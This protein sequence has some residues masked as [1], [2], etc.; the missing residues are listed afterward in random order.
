MKPGV[1]RVY[2]F[3]DFT[4]DLEGHRLA[5][6]T[7]EIPLQP[8]TFD[9]L[10]CLLE[11]PGRL[12]TKRELHDRVWGDVAVTDDALTRCIVA[13]RK[14]LGDGASRP[15]YIQTVP[16]LG[17]RFI[18]SVEAVDALSIEPSV[19]SGGGRTARSLV[20]L[21]FLNLSQDPEQEYF[22]DGFTDLLIADLGRIAALNVI[23]RTSAMS[24]RASAKPLPEIGR[25]LGVDAAVEGS[26]LRAGSR[27]RI[28]VQLIDARRDRHLW[29]DSYER[30]LHDILRL[31]REVAQD[32]ASAIR[33]TLTPDESKRLG[34]AR[35]VDPEV[36]ELYLRG[37]Y[38]WHKRTA[39]GVA[40]SVRLFHAAIE[41]DA[42]Y[43]P[44]YAGL[45]QASGVAGFFGYVPPSQAF[46]EMKAYAARALALDPG[47]AEAHACTGAVRLFYE[48]D[49]NAAE[50]CF[51]RALAEN[52]SYPVAHEWYGWCLF[53]LGRTDAGLAEV[54][55]ARELDPLS[56]HARAAE[57]MSLYFARR[58][59][60]AIEQLNA[61]MELDARFPD[62]H[63]GLG[64][65][66]LQLGMHD[67]AL[68]Q[69]EEA[70]TLSGRSA[71]DVASLGFA[72]GDAGRT[73]DARALLSELEARTARGYVPAIYFAAIH[74]G[75]GETE[76]ACDRLEHAFAERSSWLVFLRAEPWWD[77]LRT[78]SRFTRLLDRMRLKDE[79]RGLIVS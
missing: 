36:H 6:G 37:C 35:A 45:A 71:E 51:L 57:G 40:R 41:R 2:R 38:F 30:D 20:V 26:I 9:T 34:T 65:N 64:L 75:L 58:H 79:D 3:G 31:Q 15:L 76:R 74:A 21:P 10:R 50:Q 47:L 48:W 46:A 63:C 17:Y 14:A 24:Y 19:A 32:V 27:V 39:D 44:A 77:R 11:R 42:L 61:A 52:A 54:R 59:E 7:R 16:R 69:F 5:R 67:R 22:A 29:A 13:V 60:R 78:C 56:V 53:A 23:S 28:T 49:W 18:G 43:A 68:S 55:R 66:Y 70:L 1:P 4:L 72:Y 12:V 33:V 73:A 62:A 8:K 25:E